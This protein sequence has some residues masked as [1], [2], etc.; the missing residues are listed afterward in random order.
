VLL[1]LDGCEKDNRVFK[2]LFG[3]L[4]N[5]LTRSILFRG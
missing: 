5:L 1:P 4:L 2:F 3:H